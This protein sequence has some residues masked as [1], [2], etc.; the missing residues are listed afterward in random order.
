MDGNWIISWGSRLLG[1]GLSLTAAVVSILFATGVLSQISI[2][3]VVGTLGSFA[4]F[5]G[6][7]YAY[8]RLHLERGANALERVEKLVEAGKAVSHPPNWEPTHVEVLTNT[9]NVT[10]V[11]LALQKLGGLDKAQVR[12]RLYD[13]VN[14]GGTVRLLLSNPSSPQL[15]ARWQDEGGA[16]VFHKETLAAHIIELLEMRNKL[17]KGKRKRFIVKLYDS[18]PTF[19]LLLTDQNLY[20][21]TYTYGLTGLDCPTTEVQGNAGSALREF[22]KEAVDRLDAVD[23]SVKE[24]ELKS[25]V[26]R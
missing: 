21:F 5:L 9:K 3:V 11:G 1:F 14:S 16:R 6:L 4:G 23:A 8:D 24:Q 20:T 18:Y 12:Q 26:N 22:L 10:M 7:A 2:E 17:P 13:I 19:S 15:K 25:L